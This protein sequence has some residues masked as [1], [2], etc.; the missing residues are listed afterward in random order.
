MTSRQEQSAGTSEVQ[1]RHRF[2]EAR[3]ADWLNQNV[4]GYEGPLTV[5]QFK[6]GQSNPTYKVE[7]PHRSYV[8]RRKPPGELVRSAH[9]VDREFRVISALHPTGF[10]VPRPFGLCEDATVIGTWFYVMEYVD[11]RIFWDG[12]FPGV[13]PADKSN[14]FEAMNATIARLHAIEPSSVGLSDYGRPANYFVRQINRWSRQYIED[15]AAGRIREMDKLVEWLPQHIPPEEKAT[16]VHGDFRSDNM[17]FDPTEPRVVAVIDWELSTLGE[18]LA[19]YFH[20]LMMYRLP[21]A[22][23]GIF[24]NDFRALN[25]PTEEEYLAAYCRRTGRANG[26]PHPSFYMAFSI[27]RLAAIAHGIRGR[28]TRG[29]ASS[30]HAQEISMLVEQLA[31]LAWAEAGGGR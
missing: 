7:T 6:G 20:H 5:L 26:V 29:T 11:G 17:I 9:A 18:P 31:E 30:K 25:I 15:E 22:I 27:F 21:T 13:S 4:E 3:L 24:G 19:D 8:L 1:D 12:S 14:Y 16:I 2:D 23:M 28:V 10:P